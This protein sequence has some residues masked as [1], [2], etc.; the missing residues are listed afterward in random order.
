MCAEQRIFALGQTKAI[1]Y[2][3]RQ[4]KHRDTTVR[5]IGENQ[6]LSSI[7]SGYNLQH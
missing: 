4:Y 7:E 2:G 3:S 5:G 6:V 1:T